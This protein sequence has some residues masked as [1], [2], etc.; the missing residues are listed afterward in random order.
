[1]F[2]KFG[3]VLQKYISKPLLLRKRKFHIR[4]YV[5]AVSALRVYFYRNCLALCA[6]KMYRNS[7][8]YSNLGAHIT[9]T[10]YQ[11]EVD[12]HFREQ[13][14][15]VEWSAESISRILVRDGTFD[16]LVDAESAVHSTIDA[17]CAITGELFRAY[18]SE[19]GVFAPIDGCF[20]HYGLDFIV[21]D[22]WNVYLLEVNPGP[23]FKQTGLKLESLI[24][25]LMGC[26]IDVALLPQVTGVPYVD[27]G[28]L[29][30]VYEQDRPFSHNC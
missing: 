18:K 14:C 26:T 27:T 16:N 15:V 9:N 17:M 28:Q 6:G 7:D 24:E 5:L 2:D 13:F 22:S 19:F 29:A 3:R 23:D 8:H 11:I 21:D 12:P 10:A 1:M 30:L 25:N 20:E 4:A